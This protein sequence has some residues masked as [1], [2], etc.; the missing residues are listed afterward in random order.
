MF[1]EILRQKIWVNSLKISHENTGG[2]D[3]EITTKKA[4]AGY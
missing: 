3:S 2:N 4:V 1:L